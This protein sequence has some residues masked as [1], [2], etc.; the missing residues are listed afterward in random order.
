M[1]S[2]VAGGVASGFLHTSSVD[3]TIGARLRF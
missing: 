3:P 2:H 1:V